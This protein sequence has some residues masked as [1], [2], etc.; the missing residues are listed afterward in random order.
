MSEQLINIKATIRRTEIKKSKY[1]KMW[2][3][4]KKIKRLYRGAFYSNA[5]GSVFHLPKETVQ[6]IF[7][8]LSLCNALRMASL[9]SL[10]PTTYLDD[11][12]TAV[13]RLTRPPFDI[14]RDQICQDDE[15]DLSFKGLGDDDLV[16]FASACAK[17]A[18][19]SV[20]TLYLVNNQIGDAGMQ[21]FSTALADGALAQ[22][23]VL[24]LNGNQIGNAGMQAFSEALANGAMAG[25][26][27]LRLGF[28]QIGDAGMQAFS[29]ALANGALA[30]CTMLSLNNNQIGAKGLE[31]LS[32]V[33]ATGALASCQKLS[34]KGNQI[35]DNGLETLSGALA[36]GAMASLVNLYVDDGPLGTE[37]PALKA[38]CTA[39]GIELP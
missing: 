14:S 26:T 6:M 22:C 33:L 4:E 25:L 37:H 18:L 28:N 23:Q 32:G 29:T 3:A 19:A 9:D 12:V 20:A 31:A 15:L 39:R 30:Q 36:A 1:K 17:G 13:L 21:A 34:L 11:R 24:W 10:T 16:L 35:G 2:S 38:A 7:D 27:E 8:S 5:E